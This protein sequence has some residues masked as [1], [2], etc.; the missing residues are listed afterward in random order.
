M[1]AQDTIAEE[2]EEMDFEGEMPPPPPPDINSPANPA[3]PN[4]PPEQPPPPHPVATTPIHPGSRL[5]DPALAGPPA[6]DITLTHGRI[7]RYNELVTVMAK[8]APVPNPGQVKPDD[9]ITTFRQL[10]TQDDLPP[11]SFVEHSTMKRG[12]ALQL[13]VT[14]AFAE[15]LLETG[16]AH[17]FPTDARRDFDIT[18][19]MEL[20]NEDNLPYPVAQAEAAHNRERAAIRAGEHRQRMEATDRTF[21]LALDL[22]RI[23]S[24]MEESEKER[25]REVCAQRLRSTFPQTTIRREPVTTQSGHQRSRKRYFICP[26][27][28]I[29]PREYLARH[30]NPEQV[31]QLRYIDVGLRDPAM[32]RLTETSQ[33]LLGLQPCCFRTACIPPEDIA[34]EE[35]CNAWR[36]F[37]A[38]QNLTRGPTVNRQEFLRRQEE[39]ARKRQL[40]ISERRAAEEHTANKQRRE[41]CQGWLLGRCTRMEKHLQKG[42]HGSEEETRNIVCASIRTIGQEG[43]DPGYTQCPFARLNIPCPYSHTPQN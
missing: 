6:P 32:F 3:A 19:T 33:T 36:L 34:T 21:C 43:Y 22:P 12:A 35:T 42:I 29:G 9:I 30:T 10:A 27:Q 7:A 28:S 31:L 26:T 20:L 41:V 24:K 37:R 8:L 4:P 2:G 15:I 40:Q 1:R 14:A 18:M 23:A 38:R 13:T 5:M 39:K 17:L 11:T 16:T 25:M